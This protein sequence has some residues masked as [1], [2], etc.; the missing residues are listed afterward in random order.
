MLVTDRRHRLWMMMA[1]LLLLP[2]T[3]RAQATEIVVG[4][5]DLAW[6][7]GEGGY[8]EA[9]FAR[10]L[11]N[12]G[13]PGPFVFRM[14]MPADWTMP[15]HRHDAAENITVLSGTLYM[16]FAADGDTVTLPPGSFLSVPAGNPMWAWTGQ[17]GVD[18]QIHGTGPFHTT[19][20]E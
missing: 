5:N 6:N 10:V 7:H 11:G 15:S 20:V 13:E 16:K 18:L 2:A 8:A 12:P 4:A 3:V 1:A 9:T 19:P 14:R 17:E